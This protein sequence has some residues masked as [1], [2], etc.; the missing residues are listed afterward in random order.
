MTSTRSQLK[1]Y[2]APA[3]LG[4]R[5]KVAILSPYPTFAFSDE[6]GCD[7]RSYNDNATWTVALAKHLAALP[8]TEV[9]VLT[10]ATNIPA[11]KTLVSDQVRIHFIKAPPKHKTLTLWQFD[12]LRL[13]RVLD[14][15]GPDIVHGQGVECQYG[16]VAVTGKYPH[17]LTIHGIPH[18]ANKA[19]QVGLFSN[20][21]LVAVLARHC[22]RKARNI[23]VINPF[24]EESYDLTG[25]R[26]RLFPIPNA[27]G[28][29]AFSPPQ[30]A[31]E[32]DLILAVG[33]IDRRKGFDVLLNA[34]AILRRR[35]IKARAIIAGPA[36][37]PGVLAWLQQFARENDL[38][39]EFTGFLPPDQILPLQQRC[40]VFALSSR[41]E[42]AP[43]VV[44][45]AMAAR[46]PVVASRVAGLPY[47][48]RDGETGLLFQSENAT[49]L[50]D[51]LEV[52]LGDEARRARMGEAARQSALE[53]YHPK[54]VAEKTRA[55][56][57]A[58]LAGE[59]GG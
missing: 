52:L 10:E 59:G 32:R 58:V 5:L 21:R 45:E 1:T 30:R 9:H 50:A 16:Y 15:I 12:R 56:Y 48:I 28:E 4:R 47:M 44:A 38:P 33:S 39:V 23:V 14:E 46:T 55:A 6:L 18:L 13:N 31:R 25:N 36:P 26:Y 42:T 54:V 19:L 41:H 3:K 8:E 17:L 22:L 35:N 11:S 53:T 20:W 51:R 2:A 29:Q 34:L 57:E 27:I 24:V 49:E 40:T 7:T 37:D 43:M